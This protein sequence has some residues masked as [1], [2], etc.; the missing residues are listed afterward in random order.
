MTMVYY[1]GSV[2]NALLDLFPDIGM[3]LS[4]IQSSETMK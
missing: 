1:K 4:K 3:E 2:Q